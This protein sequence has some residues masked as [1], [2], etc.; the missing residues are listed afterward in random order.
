MRSSPFPDIVD[1]VTVRL[2]AAV[3]LLVSVATLASQQWWL[4]SLL[5]V[6]FTLRAT[7]GPRRSPVARM[8][9]SWVRPRVP[10]APRPTAGPPKRFAAAIGAALTA[11]ATLAYGLSVATGAEGP[12]VAVIG[13]TVVMV[14]FP[15]LESLLGLCVGCVLFAQLMRIGVVPEEVCLDCA[16]ISRR[17][18]ALRTPVS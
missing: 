14:V 3:V 8:V 13:I 17:A 15:A 7:L 11:T 6:D 5:A 1:D 12:L 4:L 2:I 16:D 18:Q 10:A 9:Q